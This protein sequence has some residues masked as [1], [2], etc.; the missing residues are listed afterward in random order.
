MIIRMKF[1]VLGFQSVPQPAIP[2]TKTTQCPQR[3]IIFHYS[4]DYHPSSALGFTKAEPRE[5]DNQGRIFSHTHSDA[6]TLLQLLSR[7]RSLLGVRLRAE[8]LL[9]PITIA[10]VSS[11]ECAGR[12]NSRICA[13]L[14]SLGG[15]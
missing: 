12:G 1:R 13:G 10:T 9:R 15:E 6:H 8:Y 4:P 2:L 14:F 5:G 3:D 11:V 7:Y